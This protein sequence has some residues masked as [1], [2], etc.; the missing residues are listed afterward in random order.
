MATSYKVI[1]REEGCLGEEPLLKWEPGCPLTLSAVQISRNTDTGQSYLQAKATNISEKMIGEVHAE[2]VVLYSDGS[3][4]TVT[5]DN[6]DADINARGIYTFPAVLL[7][8]GDAVRADMRIL[9]VTLEEGE[10]WESS[11]DPIEI[12][13]GEKLDL[14]EGLTAVRNEILRNKACRL[15]PS[16]TRKVNDK[17][18]YWVCTCGQI[19]IV[20]KCANCRIAKEAALEAEDIESLESYSKVLRAREEEIA[21]KRR[22]RIEKAKRVGLRVGPVAIALIVA[23]LVAVN[24]I[25][26]AIKY[27]DI[28]KLAESGDYAAALRQISEIEDFD[29]DSLYAECER[30]LIAKSRVGDIVQYG[31]LSDLTTPIKWRILEK[32]TEGALLISQDVLGYSE[33]DTTPTESD[34]W[35]SSDLRKRLNEGGTFYAGTF[36][37]AEKEG[38]LSKEHIYNGNWS[39]SQHTYTPGSEKRC[40]DKVYLLNISE[41]ENYLQNESDRVGTYNGKSIAWWISDTKNIDNTKTGQKVQVFCIY[42]DG[43]L[44]FW[45]SRESIGVR[46]VIWVKP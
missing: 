32:D 44:Y 37:A 45:D 4:E 9:R 43:S 38:I 2:G 25:I 42:P 29:N 23:A 35:A 27:S 22:Q 24:V 30:G 5:F 12:E 20:D 21:E 8:K 34:D 15:V 1:F 33:F 46:P 26:P 19:N 28:A 36:T 40:E 16:A 31:V 17:D 41:V 11:S 10:M 14:P 3:S 18:D 7:S 39:Y 6:L 13:L